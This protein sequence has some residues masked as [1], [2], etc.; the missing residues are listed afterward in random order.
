MNFKSILLMMPLALMGTNQKQLIES[1]KLKEKEIAS[2]IKLIDEKEA[3]VDSIHENGMAVYEKII[4]QLSDEGLAE[5]RKEVE[6]YQALILEHFKNNKDLIPLLKTELKVSND[7]FLY[8]KRMK[9]IFIR[10]YM[11]Y[12]ALHELITQYEKTLNDLLITTNQ[13]NSYEN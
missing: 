1:K 13:L 9:Y 11:E 10:F 2:L 12:M 4:A 5:Y 7:N 3:L 8:I 6:E